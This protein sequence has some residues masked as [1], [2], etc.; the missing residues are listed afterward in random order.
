MPAF[1]FVDRMNARVADSAIGRHFRLDGSGHPKTRGGA[2]F[3]SELRAGLTTFAA[4][5][6]FLI[7]SDYLLFFSSLRFSRYMKKEKW[8]RD[9][10]REECG[11][12]IGQL[13][14]LCLAFTLDFGSVDRSYIIS[15]NAVILAGTGGTCV[16]HSTD[17]IADPHCYTNPEY[18]ACKLEVQ[19]DLVRQKPSTHLNGMCQ[20]V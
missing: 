6:V 9:L 4:M 13:L 2:V 8:F 7:Q 20:D 3:T 5:Y 1:A 12:V 19:R 14:S 10:E 15:V 11:G 17:P 16:C 18:D